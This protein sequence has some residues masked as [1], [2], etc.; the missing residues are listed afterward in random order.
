MLAGALLFLKV[1]QIVLY[2]S[3]AFRLYLSG[4]SVIYRYLTAFSV[5]EMLRVA[6]AAVLPYG[7]NLYTAFYV[8]TQPIAWIF[9]SLITLEVYQAVFRSKR[10]IASF[11]RRVIPVAVG[12][13]VLLAMG[14]LLLQPHPDS[15]YFNLEIYFAV[16]RAVNFSLLCFVLLLIGFLTWFPVP[17]ARNALVHSAVFSLYFGVKAVA[18]LAR[19]LLGPAVTDRANVAVLCVSVVSLTLWTMLLRRS[20]EEARVRT[21]YRRNSVD[22]E[23][24]MHQLESINRTLLRSAK[25]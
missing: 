14:T 9:Y 4:L 2:A 13:S 12:L 18:V 8:I 6:T 3:L 17:L 15:P 21:G 23:R 19:T 11:S 22:E 5:F 16:E 25:E 10:G 1:A 24:L 7:T 20:G